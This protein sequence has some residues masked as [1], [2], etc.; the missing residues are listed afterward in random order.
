MR[1]V[2]TVSVSCRHLE[3]A[4]SASGPACGLGCSATRVIPEFE[5]VGLPCHV[6]A[7]LPEIPAS[8][9][10]AGGEQEEASRRDDPRRYSRASLAALLAAREAWN[11]AGVWNAEQQR[12][13]AHPRALGLV[14]ESE[15]GE[16]RR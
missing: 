11:D 8:D 7:P 12:S 15:K 14:L 9:S 2:I 1:T 13:K 16:R 4:V 5:A 3:S 10:P 6:A